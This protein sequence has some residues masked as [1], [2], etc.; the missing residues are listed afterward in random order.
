VINVQRA[1]NPDG[2]IKRV[3]AGE[4]RSVRLLPALAQDLREYRLAVG[5]P[6]ERALIVST[7]GAPWTKSEWQWWR[8]DRWARRAGMPVSTPSRGRTTAATRSR[9]CCSPRP[10]ADLRGAPTRALRRG[11]APH[12]CAPD[13]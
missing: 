13:R 3:K 7:D 4:R 11:A 1:C 6:P 12:V 10:P 8:V 2:S 9:A 5:R